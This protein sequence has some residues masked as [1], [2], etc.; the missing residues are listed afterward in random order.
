MSALS[1]RFDLQGPLLDGA[2]ATLKFHFRSRTVV[3]YQVTKT[4]TS[5]TGSASRIQTSRVQAPR[6][7]APRVQ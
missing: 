2:A 6:V 5:V 7:Q 4:G 3:T 1:N